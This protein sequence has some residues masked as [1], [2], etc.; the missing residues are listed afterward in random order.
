MGSYPNKNQNN[1]NNQN[2]NNNQVIKNYYLLDNSEVQILYDNFMKANHIINSFYDIK[3][4]DDPTFN[5][6]KEEEKNILLDYLDKNKSNFINLF[7]AKLNN[8]FFTKNS[9]KELVSEFIQKEDGESAFQYKIRECIKTIEKHKEEYEIK[10]LTVML[11]G[12][13]GVG[14]STLINEVL[15]LEG[16]KKAEVKTGPFVTVKYK[17]YGSEYLEFL[18]LID[19]RGIELNEQYGAEQ[20]QKEAFQFIEERKETNDPNKFVSCIW[21]CITGNRFQE[22]ERKLLNSLRTA[23]GDSKIPI[24]LIYTQATDKIAINEMKEYI[25]EINLDANFI[26]VLAKRKELV[27]NTVLEPF[28]IDI[29]IKETLNKCKKALNG[30]MFSVI[31]KSISK[32]VLE[33]LES[34]N[35]SDKDYITRMMKLSFINNFR[36]CPDNNIF[37]QFIIHLLGFNIKIFFEKKEKKVNENCHTIFLNSDLFTNFIEVMIKEYENIGDNLVEPM[38]DKK[39]REFIDLQVDIQKKCKKEISFKNQRKI[40]DFKENIKNFLCGSYHFI[41]QKLIIDY[42]FRNIYGK[43]TDEFVNQLNSLTMRILERDNNKDLIKGCFMIKFND[44][45]NRLKSYQ[46]LSSKVPQKFKNNINIYNT[47]NNLTSDNNNNNNNIDYQKDNGNNINNLNENDKLK[48]TTN[49][50]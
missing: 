44:F 18:K 39:A 42:I 37:L 7:K 33:I 36:C 13:S 16:G 40:N 26:E 24:I 17:E 30:E 27:N 22:A 34:Q 38:L 20:V 10:Y 9:I 28:G 48:L 25:K 12:S 11:V 6:L 14:K 50:V 49:N 15:N 2:L 47:R 21:Y 45:E 41:A 31:T 29:L 23:Y 3:T 32:K 35:D 8:A 5:E 1:N 19:T 43:I 46:T 4:E